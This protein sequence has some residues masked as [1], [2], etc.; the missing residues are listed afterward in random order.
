MTTHSDLHLIYML[1]HSASLMACM[2]DVMVKVVYYD[3]HQQFRT[4]LK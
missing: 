1:A 4:K 3:G 2:A